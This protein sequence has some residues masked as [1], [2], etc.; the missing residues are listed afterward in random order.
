[1]I[2]E[3]ENFRATV[4]H[5]RPGRIMY[6]AGFTPDLERR[7]KQHV[8]EG[9]DIA[10]HY[11]FHK[12]A[13]FGMRPPADLPALD[14]TKYWEGVDLPPGT[15]FA[16]GLA[17]VPGS[18]YHFSHYI[19]PL[20]NAARLADIEAYPMH[21][22]T[23]WDASWIEQEVQK[24]HAQGIPAQGWVGHMYESAW[25]IRGY[26]Q[27]LMDIIERPAW[28]D[29]LL[30]RIARQNMIA[31]VAFARAGVDWISCGDDVANQNSLMFSPAIWRKMF[32]AKWK[33]IWAEI[34]E[35]NPAC[36]IWYHSDGNIA[37]I[38]GDLVEAGV[39]GGILAGLHADDVG[40]FFKRHARLQSGDIRV[41]RNGQSSCLIV[42]DDLLTVG[43]PPSGKPVV[44]LAPLF[45]DHA[46]QVPVSIRPLEA[47]WPKPVEKMA[48]P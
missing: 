23:E 31:A 13:W 26:E 27:F 21:D 18:M 10:T 46:V 29:C 37:Q 19:S 38:I 3:L 39:A 8:G 34:K 25:Q 41:S 35:I 5:R 43:L 47:R 9:N 14:Y 45:H 17:L 1:M 11:G 12:C 36:Q 40:V 48:V 22:M 28:A 30:E 16:G 2:T 33:R 6:R 24:A 4:E 20:R 42:V 15:T 44:E 32:H 7:L